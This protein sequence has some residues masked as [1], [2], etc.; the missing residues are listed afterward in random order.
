[1]NHTSCLQWDCIASKKY[2]TLEEVPDGASIAVADDASNLS[3]NL[4]DLQSIGWLKLKEI[5]EDSL[6]TTFDIIENPKNLQLVEMD[7]FSR[8]SAMDGDVDLAMSFFSNQSQ[9]KYNFNLLKLFEEN[10]SYPIIAV[11]R[12]EDKETQWVDDFMDALASETQ[13]ER[14]AEQN[15]P[16]LAWKVLF[17]VAE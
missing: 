4:E 6:Y 9:A 5:P 10:V 11:V 2:K 12:E 15:K 17:E 3:I 13:L 7:M 16:S 14:I 8:F 1:M